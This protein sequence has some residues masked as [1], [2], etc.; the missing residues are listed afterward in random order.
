MNLYGKKSPRPTASSIKMNFRE[1]VYT[2]I[3]YF[4]EHSKNSYGVR[5][6]CRT[7]FGNGRFELLLRCFIINIFYAII[8]GKYRTKAS[9]WYCRHFRRRGWPERAREKFGMQRWGGFVKNE[10]ACRKRFF[11]FSNEIEQRLETGW[12]FKSKRRAKLARENTRIRKRWGRPSGIIRTVREPGECST[13]PDGHYYSPSQ[14]RL[15]PAASQSGKR[16]F[17]PSSGADD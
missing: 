2:A 11:F 16:R 15:R 14:D 5:L 12:T 7:D 8:S 1:N 13:V 10:H 9:V 4:S 6:F 3:V 17:N